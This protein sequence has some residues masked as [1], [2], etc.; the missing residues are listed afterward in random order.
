MKKIYHTVETVP[1]SNG[2]IVERGKF[3]THYTYIHDLW[4]L[5]HIYTWPLTFLAWYSTDNSM[6][7]VAVLR[8]MC[9][10]VYMWC[11]IFLFCLSL[12]CVLYV[13][14]FFGLSIFDCPFWLPLLIFSNV[15]LKYFYG[16]KHFTKSNSKINKAVK[17]LHKLCHKLSFQKRTLWTIINRIYFDTWNI[18]SNIDTIINTIACFNN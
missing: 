17:N 10:F 13:A 1:K 8:F 4:P 9:L 7:N 16:P 14:S 2:N 11:P 3:D 18:I 15:Y 12:S 6:K 5:T